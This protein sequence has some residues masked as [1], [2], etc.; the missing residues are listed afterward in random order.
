[1][2]RQSQILLSQLTLAP[3]EIKLHFETQ[4][5]ARP[6]LQA[7]LAVGSSI[8]NSSMQNPGL[9]PSGSGNGSETDFLRIGG[10][11]EIRF[12]HPTVPVGIRDHHNPKSTFHSSL[13][14]H[15]FPLLT[16]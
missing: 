3:S 6:D 10:P 8:D 9:V 14:T 7:T 5:V 2:E 11:E 12:A 4:A 13:L 16:S 1:M 15:H